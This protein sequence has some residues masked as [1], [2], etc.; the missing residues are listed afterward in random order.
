MP[1]HDQWTDRYSR[2]TRFAP[3]GLTGQE[4]LR[5]AA[6]LIIG[7]GALGASLAQHMVRAGV[8]TVRIADR[9]YVEPSN[10]QRQMLF[11][12][13]DA[14]AALPK[15]V[16]AANKLRRINR[17]VYVEPHVVDVTARNAAKLAEGTMLVLDGTDNVQTRLAMSDSCFRN[18]IPMLYGGIAGSHGMCAT[19]IPGETACLRC[20]IGGTEEG[21]SGETCETIGVISP[22]VDWIAT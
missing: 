3:I 4:R 2:Q 22:I 14:Y 20:L 7:C 16:A 11:D 8:G 21:E 17:D 10:L 5:E 12:E 19:L 9:D 15:A 18:G 6:V 1:K 13:E